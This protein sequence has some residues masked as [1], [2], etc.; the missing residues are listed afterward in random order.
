MNN[1]KTRI[2]ELS[3][4]L[5][6][7]NRDLLAI[8]EVLNIA[9][10]SHS[11]TITEEEV[12]QIRA[13]AHNK[14]GKRGANRVGVHRAK[15]PERPPRKPQIQRIVR[16]GPSS[17][18]DG[19]RGQSAEGKKAPGESGGDHRLVAPP[20]RPMKPGSPVSATTATTATTDTVAPKAPP[21]K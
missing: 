18:D 11:S 15:A 13:E 20:A 7:E 16:H 4:E 19:P 8:C 10:K 17:E 12:A 5:D 2:Y 3:K 6:L 21:P 14:F 1:G 9:V